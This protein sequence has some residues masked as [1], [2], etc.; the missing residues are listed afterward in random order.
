MLTPSGWQAF[1]GIVET[2]DA[3]TIFL[4]DGF[5]CTKDHK[6]KIDG[7]FVAASTLEH[8]PSHNQS[9]FDLVNVSNG[10]EY[11]TDSYISHNCLYLDEFAFVENNQAEEFFTAVFPTLSAS[12]ESRMIISSTPRGQNHFWKIWNEA[13]RGT[14]GFVTFFAPWYEHPDRD[15]KWFDDQKAALGELKTEQEINCA[16]LGSSSTLLTG[17]TLSSL[18]YST[19]IQIFKDKYDG[20]KLYKH[21]E[22]DHQYV[23]TV[24]VSRGRHLDSSTFIIFDVTAQPYT[25]VASYSNNEVAPLMYAAILHTMARQYNDSYILVEINDIGA[26]VAESLHYDFE[27]ENMFWSKSGDQLGK[28]GADPYPGI[29]TTKKTKRIGCANLK[30]MI[31]KQNLLINDFQ[32]IQELS[33][34]IQSTT[35]S[36]E[37]DQ[38]FHDDMVMCGVLF[39]WLASQVWFKDLT[40][41]DMRQ[42]MYA[43]QLE[44]IEEEL[45]PFGFISNAAD[46]YTDSYGINSKEAMDFLLN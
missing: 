23:M 18:S 13:E 37:A 25:I 21:A 20:L 22:K 3:E 26:Q 14:N 41:Q 19:P 43:K 46:D 9:V 35:G 38:G 1:D 17:P 24:D 12:K 40:N 5:V 8:T 4:E 39:A 7:S 31:E 42:A 29:R 44:T 27:Y 11:Y 15:Q 45:T 16:F 6:L 10:H 32:L 34:F 2:L 33:T 36:Y 30:D 28:K